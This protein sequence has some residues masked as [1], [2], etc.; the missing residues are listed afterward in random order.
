MGK[1]YV[2]DETTLTNMATSVREHLGVETKYRPEDMPTGI[3]SVYVVGVSD[4]EEVGFNDGFF[5]GQKEGYDEGHAEG[6]EAGKQAEKEDFWNKYQRGGTVM[7]YGS[8]NYMFAGPRWNDETFHPMFDINLSGAATQALFTYNA[9]TNIKQRLEECGVK[10]T[11]TSSGG[12]TSLAQLFVSTQTKELP[13]IHNVK[14]N[15][16]GISMQRFAERSAKLVEVPYYEFFDE[17]GDFTQAFSDCASL[18]RV[19]GIDFSS[20]TTA[21]KCFT[22][23]TKLTDITVYGEIPVSISFAQSPL[24]AVSGISVIAHLKIYSDTDKAGTCTLTLKDTTKTLLAEQGAIAELD[25]KTY[26]QYI[27]DIGWNLA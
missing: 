20:A 22:N 27:T 26:D 10:I 12:I 16:N 21:S 9:C 3:D 7:G 5:V 25:G 24:T 4:G 17:V 2:I 14:N 11:S 8:A 23:C 6:Y 18:A 13:P 19:V 1:K 15:G